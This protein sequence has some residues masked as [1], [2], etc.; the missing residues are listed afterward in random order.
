MAASDAQKQAFINAAR[1]AATNYWNAQATCEALQAE[2]N[3]M[4]YDNALVPA[5]FTGDNEGLTKAQIGAVVFDTAN[6]IAAVFAAGSAT[7][8]AR[9]KR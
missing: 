3:A 2:W 8:I 4:D 9:I 6:L 7:N 1:V 5:D